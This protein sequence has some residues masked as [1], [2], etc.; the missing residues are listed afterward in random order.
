M[1]TLRSQLD[2]PPNYQLEKEKCQLHTVN[3][4]KGHLRQNVNLAVLMATKIAVNACLVRRMTNVQASAVDRPL[5]VDLFSVIPSLQEASVQEPLLP[6]SIIALLLNK[7]TIAVEMISCELIPLTK[8]Q[9]TVVRM[10][11][12]CM[13]TKTSAMAMLVSQ[14]ST[15]T[16]AVAD[17]SYRSLCEDA[18][19]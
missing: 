13:V 14:T 11:V 19:L 4:Q 18:Y 2:W 12:K 15:V 17:I 5:M 1:E 7:M 6:K 10:D 16:V 8:F 9:I 3:K